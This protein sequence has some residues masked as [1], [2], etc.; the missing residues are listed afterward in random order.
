MS[1]EEEQ[2]LREACERALE[3]E[4]YPLAESE[5][6]LFARPARLLALLDDLVAERRERAAWEAAACA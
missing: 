1:E 6:C 2:S 3:P 5:L 4:M